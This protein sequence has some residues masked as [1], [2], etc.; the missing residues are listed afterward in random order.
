M[1]GKCRSKEMEDDEWR[2][3]NKERESENRA[4]REL[5]K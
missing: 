3:S 5:V 1:S 4:K 2:T